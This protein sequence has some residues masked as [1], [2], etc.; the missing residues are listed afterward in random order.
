MRGKV[1]QRP[2]ACNILLQSP[3]QREIRV[4]KGDRI[5]FEARVDGSFQI[6]TIRVDGS[7]Q[8]PL[9]TDAEDHESPSWSPDGRY[10]AFSTRGGGA[11]R[12]CVMNA[13]GTGKRVLVEAPGCLAPAWSPRLP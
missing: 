12:I 1:T 9:T 2:R 3:N 6:H 13:N 5:A 4:K 8:M 11:S 7:D 10:I